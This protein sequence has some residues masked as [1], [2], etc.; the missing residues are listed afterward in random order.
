MKTYKTHRFPHNLLHSAQANVRSCG[1][2]ALCICVLNSYVLNSRVC[3]SRVKP[4]KQSRYNI[5]LMSSILLLVEWASSKHNRT[6]IYIYIELLAACL[7]LMRT[8]LCSINSKV[9]VRFHEYL[10]RNLDF[11]SRCWYHNHNQSEEEEKIR[12]KERKKMKMIDI[13]WYAVHTMHWNKSK[14]FQF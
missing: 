13:T 5:K 8:F 10:L 3:I 14:Y 2:A 7:C 11:N 6:P 12:R 1:R 9:F 4:K